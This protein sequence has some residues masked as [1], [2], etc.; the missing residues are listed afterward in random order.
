MKAIA[1]NFDTDKKTDNRIAH[2]HFYLNETSKK[3]HR[4]FNRRFNCINMLFYGNKT[5]Q[6]YSEYWR[7]LYRD[8]KNGPLLWF[9]TEETIDR[10]QRT[11]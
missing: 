1:G 3:T 4:K 10:V 11:K 5:L 7:K 9:S 2:D 8:K 6:I